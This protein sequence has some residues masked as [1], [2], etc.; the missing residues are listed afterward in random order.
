[1]SGKAKAFGGLLCFVAVVSFI[2]TFGIW[3]N[4]LLNFLPSWVFNP[5]SL[6]TPRIVGNIFLVSGTLGWFLNYIFALVYSAV[7]FAIGAFAILK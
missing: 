7:L 5:L 4:V 1:M 2:V 3:H 6:L